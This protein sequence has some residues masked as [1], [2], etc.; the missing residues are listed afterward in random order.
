[1]VKQYQAELAL[2]ARAKLAE[3]P[4]WSVAEQALYWVD[5]SSRTINRFDPVTQQNKSWDM[6][7]EPGCTGS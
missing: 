4:L 2:D 5:I 3:C 1:M 6:P 7:S